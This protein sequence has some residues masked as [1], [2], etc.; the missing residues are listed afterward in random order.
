MT[1]CDR[2][3]TPC[4]IGYFS[5][6]DTDDR[7]CRTCFNE[8]RHVRPLRDRARRRYPDGEAK[9][10]DEYHAHDLQRWRRRVLDNAA[11]NRRWS[12]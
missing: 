1:T 4:T 2:C 6:D 5:P 9:P 10:M 8:H 3:Q 11:N 12:R 7:L